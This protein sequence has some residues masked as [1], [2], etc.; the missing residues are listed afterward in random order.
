MIGIWEIEPEGEGTRYT[1]RARHWSDETR[2]QHEE[3][4]F[5]EGWGLCADQMVALCEQSEEYWPDDNSGNPGLHR[6]FRMTPTTTAFENSPDQ[7][8]GLE[9]NL[10]V[11]WA[12]ADV[13][14]PYGVSLCSFDETTGRG[15][16]GKREGKDG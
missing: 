4:G 8:Q 13:G 5:V 16:E 9:R 12:I 3:M 6:R 15:A 2:K 14:P 7:G 1:S 11:R 10:R